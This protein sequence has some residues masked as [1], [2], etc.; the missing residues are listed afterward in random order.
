MVDS[1]NLMKL[2]NGGGILKFSDCSPLYS[3]TYDMLSFYSNHRESFLHRLQ[4]IFYLERKQIFTIKQLIQILV[5]H[6]L[7]VAIVAEESNRGVE[8]PEF[9]ASS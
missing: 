9:R 6:L 7:N 4:C 8:S 2:A 5:P 1:G 3:N